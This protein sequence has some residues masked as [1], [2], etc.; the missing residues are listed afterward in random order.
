MNYKSEYEA[1]THILI[2]R[3]ELTKQLNN[4][5]MQMDYLLMNIE[6]GDFKDLDN[7]KGAMQELSYLITSSAKVS[8]RAKELSVMAE[9]LFKDLY[10]T[11]ES[12]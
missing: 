8:D 7:K 3:N 6:K 1:Y 12:H 5:N 2:K 4:M 9:K 11:K 10:Q